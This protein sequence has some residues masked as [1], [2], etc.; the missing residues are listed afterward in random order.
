V[1]PIVVIVT[2]LCY[3]M[4]FWCCV[5]VF[6]VADIKPENLL[7]SSTPEPQLKLCDFGFARTISSRGGQVM[8]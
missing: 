7:V 4:F 6:V 3:L 8:W 5:F 1:Y 2:K